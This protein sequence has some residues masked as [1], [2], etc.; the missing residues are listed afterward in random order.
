MDY[1][2][3]ARL[4]FFVS[5]SIGILIISIQLGRLIGQLS[6]TV[7][8][9]RKAVGKIDSMLSEVESD[10]KSIRDK[11]F[12]LLSLFE[13]LVDALSSFSGFGKLLNFLFKDKKQSFNSRQ[14]KQEDE[15]SSE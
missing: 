15:K 3:T 4:I 10:Y 1:F 9:T 14:V 11:V 12:G 13:K 2:E 6:S 8:D 7:K 5:L